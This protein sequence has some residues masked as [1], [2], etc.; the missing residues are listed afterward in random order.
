MLLAEVLLLLLL[1]LM[2]MH[3][4]IQMPKASFSCF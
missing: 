3:Q 1:L 4:R 2:R